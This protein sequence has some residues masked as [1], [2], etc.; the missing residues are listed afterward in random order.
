MMKLPS[1]TLTGMKAIGCSHI[2]TDFF[3]DKTQNVQIVNDMESSFASLN[4]IM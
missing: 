2:F 3:F 4:L 1:Q